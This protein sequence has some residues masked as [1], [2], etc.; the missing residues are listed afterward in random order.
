MFS[1]LRKSVRIKLM[2]VVLATTL[3]ALLAAATALVIYEMRS[4]K[5]TWINDLSTQA[6]LLALISAPAL[7]FDDPGAARQNL[8]QLK[9]RRAILGAAIYDANGEIF[10]TYAQDGGDDRIP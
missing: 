6:E 9:V 10:A 8:A 3:A 7:A 2:S 5:K 4:Y 1:F